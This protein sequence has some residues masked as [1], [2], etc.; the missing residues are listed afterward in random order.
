VIPEAPF[1]FSIAGVSASLAGLAG[2]VVGLRRGS[3]MRPLDLFRLQEI[4]AFSFANV[5]FAISVVPASVVA[6]SSEPAVRLAAFAALVYAIITG[7]YLA[8]R[9]RAEGIPWTLGWLVGAIVLNGG[10]LAIGLV[11]AFT[12]SIGWY[13]ALLVVMLARPMFATDRAALRRYPPALGVT[14][15]T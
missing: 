5:L 7:L 6:G 14:W 4:V 9:T 1:L 13:E 10:V 3:D 11:T 12:G 2:L 15:K 8:R